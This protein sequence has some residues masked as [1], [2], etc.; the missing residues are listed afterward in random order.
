M[1]IIGQCTDAWTMCAKSR[2]QTHT[3]IRKPCERVICVRVLIFRLHSHD[4]SWYTYYMYCACERAHTR[5]NARIRNNQ[6]AFELVDF[7]R[8]LFLFFNLFCLSLYSLLL[9]I[10]ASHS[11]VRSL[12]YRWDKSHSWHISSNWD[13]VESSNRINITMRYTR[14]KNNHIRFIHMRLYCYCTAVLKPTWY[15]ELT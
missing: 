2:K 8:F 10:P 7:V 3:H 14:N 4:I 12:R 13:D 15:F 9:L 1:K 5:T 11:I 6:V